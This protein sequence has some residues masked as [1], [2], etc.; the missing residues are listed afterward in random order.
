MS[1][2]LAWPLGLTAICACG[3][4][5]L[6]PAHHFTIVAIGDTVAGRLPAG[7]AEVQYAF[8]AR[9][10]SI[11][12]V[13]VQTLA[14]PVLLSVSDTGRA[15]VFAQAVASPGAGLFE[16]ATEPFQFGNAPVLLVFSGSDT[17]TFRFFVY[18]V[19][20][21]PETR[22]PRFVLGDTVTESLATLADIDTF[23]VAGTAGQEVVGYVQALSPGSPG[24]LSLAVEGLAGVGSAAGDS[25]LEQESSGRFLLPSSR[26]YRLTLEA[27]H[28][29]LSGYRRYRGPYRFQLRLID[30]RPEYHAAAIAPGDTVSDER[31]DYV[32]D[33]DEFTLGGSPGQECVVF[34]QALSGSASTRFELD[35]L[36]PS[37]GIVTGIQSGGTDGD[38]LN[39]R[40]DTFRLSAGG[41]ARLRVAGVDDRSLADRGAYRFWVY[42]VDRRPE[43]AAD[44]LQ[45]GDSILTESIDV[46]GDIDEFAYRVPD[47]T[48]A[49][50]VLETGGDATGNALQLE[51]DDSAGGPVASVVAVGPGAAVPGGTFPLSPGAYV[52]RV[53]GFD[54]RSGFR[55]HYQVKPY[56][57]FRLGPESVSDTVVLGDT[58]T[59]ESLAPPGDVDDFRFF[60]TKGEHIDLAFAG[61]GTPGGDLTLQF[62]PV[63]AAPFVFV[64]SP[65]ASDSLGAHRSR[66]IDLDSTGWY[67][68]RVGGGGSPV[69]GLSDGGPYA[70]APM[71]ADTL[72][73]HVGQDIAVGD[74]VATELTDYPGDYDSY[75]ATGAPGSHLSIEFGIPAAVT[76]SPVLELDD[77]VTGD[78]LASV[79]GQPGPPFVAPVAIP[80]GGQIAIRVRELRSAGYGYLGGYRFIVVPVNT[81][82]ESV[83]DSFALGDTVRGE[84]I[85][86]G[87]DV[88]EYASKATPG[89]TLSPFYR[90]T[91]DPA[92]A[93]SLITL[94]VIDPATGAVLAGSGVAASAASVDFMT[95]GSFVVPASGHYLVRVRAYESALAT[96]P[97]EF[98]VKAVP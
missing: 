50:L 14:G 11:Y 81:A 58:V 64:D 70:F 55:G 83:P 42:P 23:V 85:F 61:L 74:T 19:R 17:G 92:P 66:R 51:L 26:D 40:T 1:P 90:L 5:S 97:Y 24:V 7:G 91:A 28:D 3:D 71:L 76:F 20:P 84:A 21:S 37:G 89:T 36:D 60:G 57:G 88:D 43:T 30:R 46:P 49:N 48:L 45:Y 68:I 79:I 12:A 4:S 2:R 27:A 16:R 69:P 33:V 9:V 41:T 77:P 44:T 80:P 96:A 72:P 94:L 75:I 59:G 78:S 86:P 65:T 98:F 54:Q 73:E 56:V 47:S 53:H 67:D 13:F 35:A 82:P 10:D 22:A 39:Q 25:D 31:L 15:I 63:S 38:L 6:G 62:G 8:P 18:P 93:G 52:L 29:F 32:G 34:L 95:P 87:L